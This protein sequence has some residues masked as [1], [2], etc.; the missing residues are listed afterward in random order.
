MKQFSLTSLQEFLERKTNSGLSFSMVDHLRWYLSSI[1]VLA[2][3][4]KVVDASP[5]TRLYTPKAAPKGITRA[6]S[7]DEVKIAVSAV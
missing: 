6:M 2:I 3:A 1:F 7:I 4:V 5:A